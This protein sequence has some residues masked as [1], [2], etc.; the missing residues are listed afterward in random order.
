MICRQVYP[1]LLGTKDTTSLPQPVQRHLDCCP[2]CRQRWERLERLTEQTRRMEAP[3]TNPAAKERLWKRL[4]EHPRPVTSS[5]PPRRQRGWR[6]LPMTLAASFLI[7]LG[8]ILGH[9]ALWNSTPSTQG[10]A[11]ASRLPVARVSLSPIVPR[12]AEQDV[13]L[14]A[15]MTPA[16]QLDGLIRM[17]NVLKDE[18]FRLAQGGPRDELVLV[19]QLY[20]QVIRRGMVGRV[21]SL[22]P[23]QR[24]TMIAPLVEQLQGTATRVEG[25][26]ASILPAM[27]ELLRPVSKTAREGSALLM[28]PG[29]G[30][31]ETT[32]LANV[33]GQAL[34]AVLVLSG[35]R[36]VEES[37]P[38]RRAN[39]SSE[40][41]QE[42]T[43]TIALLSANGEEEQAS[44]LGV[45]LGELMDR[46]VAG[47]LDRVEAD[48]VKG[49]RRAEVEQ[50]RQRAAQTTTVLER[51]LAQAPAA[52]RPGLQRALQASK[53]GRDRATKGVPKGQG[54]PDHTG[55]PWL[56]EGKEDGPRQ[57]GKSG[58]PPGLQKKADKKET[59]PRPN[60]QGGTDR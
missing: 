42:L 31:S 51:N 1:W 22:N 33:S 3:P 54:K 2:D 26:S 16:D 28:D 39:L 48:D 50:V 47:N 20:D 15:S 11:A 52:A 38:L 24:R 21:K 56:R 25:L 45:T 27:A 14:A 6:L 57:H 53:Q 30:A 40:L 60:E 10:P 35:L 41:G 29:A 58:V 23:E 5:S 19:A 8:W 34:V 12:V 59:P 36:L 43:Q 4:D 49:G 7:G 9:E 18:A 17:A 32:S 13:R 55:P 44:E 37:D 46:G